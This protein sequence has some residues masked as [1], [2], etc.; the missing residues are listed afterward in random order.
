MSKKGSGGKDTK[1]VALVTTV[2]PGRME[3]SLS[4]NVSHFCYKEVFI[5]VIYLLLKATPI[6]ME[7]GQPSECQKRY[8]RKANVGW[9]LQ[10]LP[11]IVAALAKGMGILI[12]QMLLL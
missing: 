3:R 4:C 8:N 7:I 11:E 10:T 6:R 9:P 1:T 12:P 5:C 2:A